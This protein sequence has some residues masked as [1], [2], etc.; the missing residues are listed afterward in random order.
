MK[1]TCV[2]IIVY[3]QGR[4]SPP[5]GKFEFLAQHL[6]LCNQFTYV[7]KRIAQSKFKKW[8]GYIDSFSLHR[9][10]LAIKN[11]ERYK[12]CLKQNIQVQLSFHLFTAEH[13]AVTRSNYFFR[14]KQETSCRFQDQVHRKKL[15]KHTFNHKHT[16][17]HFK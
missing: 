14:K 10:F 6:S 5:Q 15:L 8:N 12:S 3:L 4:R 2:Y 9:N 11:K 16:D 13:W 7:C 17:T 1:E